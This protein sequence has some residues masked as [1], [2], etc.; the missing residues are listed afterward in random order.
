MFVITGFEA[1][2]SKQTGPW[3]AYGY[4][5]EEDTIGH[6]DILQMCSASVTVDRVHHIRR[7]AYQNIHGVWIYSPLNLTTEWVPMPETLLESIMD[8]IRARSA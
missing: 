2:F 6:P 7:L 3:E 4:N 8:A 1:S 5:D